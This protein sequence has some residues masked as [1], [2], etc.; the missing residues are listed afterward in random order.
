MAIAEEK[1]TP[2]R[3]TGDSNKNGDIDIIIDLKEST[4]AQGF[5]AEQ[6]IHLDDLKA[7]LKKI[8]DQVKKAR[9]YSL[10]NEDEVA[11]IHDYATIGVFGD[12][13]SGKTSF[14]VSLLEACREKYGDVKVLRMI[15]P[16]LVEQKKPIVLG[17]LGMI[18]GLVEDKLDRSECAVSDT[19]AIARQGWN[20][21]MKNLATGIIAIENIGSEYSYS[22]WADEDYVL[23]TGFKKVVKANE[24]ERYF[25]EMLTQALAILNK[26]AFIL[27]FDDIDVDMSKG[28]EVL[29][30]IRRY[31]S[32]PR[33]ISIVSG[34]IKLYGMIVRSNLSHCLSFKEDAKKELM[35]NELESQYLLKILKPDNRL[36]LV[37]L[38]TLLNQGKKIIFRLAER[39]ES[40]EDAYRNILEDVGIKDKSSQTSFIRFLESM[41]L[42]SQINFVKESWTANSSYPSLYVFSSR[43]YAAGID[44]DLL[45]QNENITNIVILNYLTQTENLPDAY[46]L[47]PTFTNKDV[48]SNFVALTFLQCKNFRKEPYLM[49]DYLLRIGYL[50]NLILPMTDNKTVCNL[51][52]YAGW[53]QTMS[54]KNNIGLTIAFSQAITKNPIKDHIPLYGLERGAK[55]SAKKTRN[56]IDRLLEKHKDEFSSLLALFPFIRIANSTNNSSQNFYSI[57][58][59]LA[60]VEEILKCDSQE[61]MKAAI[62]DLKIFRTYLVPA[63]G[64]V[65]INDEEM[66]MDIETNAEYIDRLSKEMWTWKEQGKNIHLPPYAIGRIATRLYNAVL[67]VNKKQVGDSMNIMV[68]DFLNACIIEESRVKIEATEQASLNNSNPL[69]NSKVLIDNLKKDL[70]ISKLDFSKWMIVCPMLNCFV[71]AR[72]YTEITKYITIDPKPVQVKVYDI[73]NK[74]NVKDMSKPKPV[75]DEG[76]GLRPSTVKPTSPLTTSTTEIE[77][78]D[79]PESSS[80]TTSDEGISENSEAT[81]IQDD[82]P[83]NGD[84]ET[85]EHHEE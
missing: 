59:L 16:T 12:R 57:F 67:N 11:L 40:V 4:H 55:A 74:L 21:V 44:L 1:G 47:L 53:N 78:A 61:G 39:S 29:E 83:S 80:I 49:I 19:T 31:F 32:D 50:R 10:N 65:D 81:I 35:A 7:G 34:N 48:N 15:D 51:I 18:N 3:D 42:R 54:L 62:N 56:A 27:A 36:N 17:V 33:I 28:W 75:V 72:V 43:L 63:E 24:F 85:S 71:D 84:T 6:Q 58:A 79:S 52:K 30:S 26:K 68:C 64:E 25:R 38:K 2:D 13:G 46:L 69:T 60:V 23:N 9:T 66:G 82:V 22:L 37:V 77:H 76:I 45:K 20:K 14:M 5:K 70:I 41:S 8:D 73:L